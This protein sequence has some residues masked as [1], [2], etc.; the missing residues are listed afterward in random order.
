MCPTALQT[1]IQSPI[2]NIPTVKHNL[3]SPQKFHLHMN[4]SFGQNLFVLFPFCFFSGTQTKTPES[5]V[6]VSRFKGTCET[7]NDNI[8]EEFVGEHSGSLLN[9]WSFGPISDM[10]SSKRP[11]FLEGKAFPG[12][13]LH[14]ITHAAKF[15]SI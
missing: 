4:L 8:G 13:M 14:S 5:C 11:G 15:F 3:N 12:S 1:Q 2:L 7:Q 9:R 6:L 10:A